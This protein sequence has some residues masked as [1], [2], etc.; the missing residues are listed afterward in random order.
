[1]SKLVEKLKSAVWVRQIVRL[2]RQVS[3]AIEKGLGGNKTVVWGVQKLVRA[4]ELLFGFVALP[5]MLVYSKTRWYGV[6]VLVGVLVL[7]KWVKKF[8]ARYR[9]YF[10]DNVVKS[11]VTNYSFPSTHSFVAGVATYVALQFISSWWLRALVVALG[12]F[13]PFSR[14]ILNV[15]FVLDVLVGYGLGILVAA[16]IAWFQ[17]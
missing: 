9:P 13:I 4:F 3:D 6:A 12:L 16:L 5:A 8:F 14:V 1:M 11:K 15:H 7:E 10:Y 2:D 17:V